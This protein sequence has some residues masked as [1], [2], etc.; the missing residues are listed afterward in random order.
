MA[1]N[2]GKKKIATQPKKIIKTQPST[3]SAEQSRQTRRVIKR[4]SR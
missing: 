4:I 1:C 3:S 2:C